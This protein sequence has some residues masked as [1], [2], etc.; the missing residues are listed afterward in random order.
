MINKTITSNKLE[1]NPTIQQGY[2]YVQIAEHEMT[3]VQINK[4]IYN[5]KI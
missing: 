2:F 5:I 1:N 3:K 4:G